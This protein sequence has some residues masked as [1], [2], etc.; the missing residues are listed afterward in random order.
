[1]AALYAT[2]TLAIAGVF[3][4]EIFHR[5]EIRSGLLFIALVTGAA[6]YG[7]GTLR[8]WARGLG[9]FVAVAMAGLGAIALL[10]AFVTH[11]GG[12]LVPVILLGASALVAVV[13][14]TSRFD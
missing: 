9:T 5:H 14:G 8:S 13:F 3:V 10:D 1:M 4:F 12:K 2:G 11:K 6:S 7:L